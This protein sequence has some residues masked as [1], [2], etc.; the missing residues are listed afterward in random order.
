MQFEPSIIGIEE[1]ADM[2]LSCASY[3]ELRAAGARAWQVVLEDGEAVLAI[4]AAGSDQ[5]T[6]FRQ[7]AC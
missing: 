6:V 1:F 4:Q 2:K 7:R 3:S 5:V